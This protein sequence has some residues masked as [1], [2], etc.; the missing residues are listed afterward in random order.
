MTVHELHSNQPV[1]RGKPFEKG[2]PGRKP[3]SKNKATLIATQ[4]LEGD[5]DEFYQ[6]ARELALAGNSD[7]LKFFLSRNLPKQRL[8]RLELPVVKE[9]SDIIEA[10]GIVTSAVGT[11]QVTP[12]EGAALAAM[13]EA[14]ARAI[15]VYELEAKINRLEAE[16][17]QPRMKLGSVT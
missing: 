5:I 14:T 13:I 8:V 7:M 16:L 11:G 6:K 1:R 15:N 12:E 3:G 2:N 9:A 10:L 17:L 4:L